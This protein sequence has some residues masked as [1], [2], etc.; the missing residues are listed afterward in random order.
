ML[1]G[2]LSIA[3]EPYARSYVVPVTFIDPGLDMRARSKTF[4]T[5]SL[6]A[7]TT[8]ALLLGVSPA[9][10]QAPVDKNA[11]PVVGTPSGNVPPC[12][13]VQEQ[14]QSLSEKTKD[15]LPARASNPAEGSVILQSSGGDTPSSAPSAQKDGEALRS[16]LDC[17][18]PAGHP[19]AMKP[20]APPLPLE[21]K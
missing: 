6:A 20:N 5:S 10:A 11:P 2:L 3:S 17:P 18:L 1:F 21:G 9:T 4:S 16:A 7:A 19:N 13:T 12:P 14:R 15:G 8:L